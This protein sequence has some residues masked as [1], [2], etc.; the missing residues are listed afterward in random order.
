MLTS[1]SPSVCDTCDKNCAL[2]KKYEE[3]I[4]LY[5][6]KE[7]RSSGE[8]SLLGSSGPTTCTNED[9]PSNSPAGLR[10]R[11]V[12][13]ELLRRRCSQLF[14]NPLPSQ[15]RKLVLL[16]I[17]NRVSKLVKSSS[18]QSI[19]RAAKCPAALLEGVL[20]RKVE[21]AMAGAFSLLKPFIGISV[22]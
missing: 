15:V 8:E 12:L 5:K 17:C 11:E 18:F 22:T 3:M 10:M 7:L 1:D 2:V 6:K 16:G 20:E 19:K 13:C 4:Q 9:T 21:G 14:R